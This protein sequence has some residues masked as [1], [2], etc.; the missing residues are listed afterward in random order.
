MFGIGEMADTK[1]IA[2]NITPDDYRAKYDECMI[3][4]SNLKSKIVELYERN[5]RIKE[6]YPVAMGDV[7]SAKAV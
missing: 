2:F 6:D 7:R 4:I 5:V 1:Q 3:E